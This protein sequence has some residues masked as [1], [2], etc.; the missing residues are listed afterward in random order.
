MK[1]ETARFTAG[2]SEWPTRAEFGAAALHRLYFAIMA[3]HVR[4]QLAT[5]LGLRLPSGRVVVRAR[6]TEP[7]IAAALDVFLNGR[8]K[9][10]TQWEFKQAGLGGLWN[11]LDKSG[12][13][14]L[15]RRRYGFQRASRRAQQRHRAQETY[16]ASRP[17]GD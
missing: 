2:R 4:D 16:F 15:W 6:W 7:A 14:D 17:E 13:H 12:T 3:S 10:P 8:V 5:E 1:S 9:W 11:R